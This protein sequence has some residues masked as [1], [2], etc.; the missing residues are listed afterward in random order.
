MQRYRWAICV[1]LALA[2]MAPAAKAQSITGDLVVNVT[3]PSGAVVAGSKLVLTEV[4]TNIK[5][6]MPTDELGNALFGQLKPGRYKLEVASAGFQPQEITDIRIQVGQ[7]A[8]VEVKLAVGQLTEAVTVS[9]AAETL[10]N[11][12]SAALGQVL[13]HRAIVNM[14]LSGRNFIQLATLS[15]GAVPIGI[16]TSPA[17]SWTGRSDMSLSIAG[18][19]ESNNSFLLN[20]IETRNARFGSVGIRPSIEA[21]QEFKIQRST[22][23]AEFGRSS[24][25]INTTLRSGTNEI[26]G[27][28]FDFWQ[29]RELNGTDFFLN[30]TGRAKPPLNFHNFGTAIGGPVTIPKLYRGE[31]RTFWFFNYEGVRQRSSSAATGL[32]PSRAQLA[33]NLADDSTGTGIFPRST[34]FC[35]A[36]PSS[37][38]CADVLDPNTR[39]PFPGNVIPSS[40]LDPTTQLALQFIPTPNVAVP[41]NLPTFPTFNTVGTPSQ[42]ND[43]DQYN[44]RLDHQFSPRDLVYGSFS[45]SDETRDLKA[46]RP[47][48][49]ESFP[50]RNRLVTTTWNRTISPSMLN[51]FRFGWNRSVT[52]RL[53]ETSFVRDYAKEVFNLK[54]IATQPIVYG[55]PSFGISGFSGIGSISQAIGATDENLQFTDNFSLIR[56]KHNMRAGF[57]ISRQAYFQV[58]NFSGNP[59]FNFDGRYS[60][61]QTT[62]GT[63]LA[64]FLLGV[65]AS[66]RGAIGDGQ[67]DM[68]ST[69][70]G[71]YIQDDWRIL[72]NLTIN[73]GIR[74]EFAASPREIYNRSLFFSPELRQVVIAGQGVRPEIVDPDYNN[75]APRFGFNWN[76]RFAKNFVV[77]GGIGV[78]YATDNFNEEQ[79][80][81]N[82]PPFF[83]AQT[84]EGNA[85]T[86]NLFMRDML[87]SFTTSPNL[88]PFSFDRLNRTPYLTQWSFGIQKSFGANWLLEAEYAGSTG[89]KL[90][91]RR[92]QN[93]GRMDPTGTIPLAQRLPFPGFGAG[94][95]LTYNGGWSSYNALTAKV[96]RRL[97][98]GLYLLGSYTWQKAL[99]LGSTDE[100]STIHSEHKKWDKGH[101]AFDVPHR[102][103]T[104]FNYQLPVGQGKKFLSGIGKAADLLLGGW[105][106]N[107][108]ATFA[109]GQF[110]TLVLGSDWLLM[111]NWTK[112]IA[113]VVGDPFAGRSLPDK[114]W[115][116]AAF[117]FPRDAAG[118]RIRVLGNAG[119]NSFQQPGLNNWDM[120]LMKNFRI[121]E[122]FN[123]QFRWE[124]FNTWNHTQ[125]GSAN[126]NTSSAVFGS[127]TGTRVTARRMQLGLKLMW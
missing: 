57:Q 127:I 27:S 28:V 24:A 126:T 76:P 33:G 19:R 53:S 64:D 100:F 59:A 81:V 75:F 88:S 1:V 52:Y 15:S 116:A 94:M 56:G 63:G 83:Q 6:E 113:Q 87:P 86:P 72:P 95:L 74:Y 97:A 114:Y 123:S 122:R 108:I 42:I 14:P 22:F 99:D 62:V 41:P 115:N 34:A 98:G 40:R 2:A 20:G 29:N 11:S 47:M 120:G 54:N 51:E 70:Y 91:Q 82:G 31:N 7:R 39:L 73:I 112:S 125:F 44:T 43:W 85:S 119:R 118:N 68:R 69:F 50:L 111:G 65:P 4:A 9:A 79:F 109:Q 78:F 60:G 13:E 36:N 110:S 107:G 117:D 71:A 93:A 61:L 101:S 103:V 124:T 8:R 23:G 21:I 77:R 5:Q 45:W 92:N 67:Q 102:F 32:Y 80:K 12:E 104:S 25:I 26:H 10:L 38:K 48:G 16:G 30:R 96:E 121:N 58:T 66:A 84:L 49:G 106:V 37:R 89:N 105:E 90:P 3:D 55:V 17:T 35:Q 46:L 18:G